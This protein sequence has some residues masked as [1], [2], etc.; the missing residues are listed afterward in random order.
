MD[1]NL[2]N[3][4]DIGVG[5][6]S[7]ADPIEYETSETQTGVATN[8]E[9]QTPQLGTSLKKSSSSGRRSSSSSSS[10][11]S[12]EAA[13]TKDGSD[14]AE[15]AD[16]A[17]VAMRGAPFA[18]FL[19]DASA[20]MQQQLELNA[21]S[22]AF[23]GVE[24]SSGSGS[25]GGAAPAAAVCLHELCVPPSEPSVAAAASGSSRSRSRAAPRCIPCTSVDWNSTG[26]VL[27]A[28]LGRNDHVGWCCANEE[29]HGAPVGLALWNVFGH[30]SSANANASAAG[31]SGASSER[32]Q[33]SWGGDAGADVA[34]LDAAE[35]P[36]AAAPGHDEALRAPDTFIPTS[37][38]LMCVAC[39][40]TSPGMVAGGTYTGEVILWD[41]GKAGDEVCVGTSPVGDYY[42]RDPVV[43]VC[44]C[45]CARARGGGSVA[46]VLTTNHAIHS[47]S[48]LPLFLLIAFSSHLSSPASPF[49]SSPLQLEWVYDVRERGHVLLSVSGCGRVLI[50]SVR[51]KLA[52]PIGGY[53]LHP[54]RNA[55]SGARRGAASGQLR[56]SAA[57]TLLGG[58]SIAAVA[59]HSNTRSASFVVGT[60]GGVLY[61]NE[62]EKPSR[63]PKSKSGG[64]SLSKGAEVFLSRTSKLQRAALCAHVERWSADSGA[65]S[66]R[67]SAIFDSEPKIEQV[68]PRLFLLFHS[69]V[70]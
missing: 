21:R 7:Q 38:C 35:R 13:S 41:T 68:G 49:L 51:N 39:H 24:L 55:R 47:P 25:L 65:R 11:S 46:C 31:G 64:P 32:D 57:S 5:C 27:A 45:V 33:W 37:S 10:S 70:D 48:P 4:H 28:S 16:D 36:P 2:Y 42:H 6:G 18:V 43:K 61:Q 3:S 69:I 20:L 29:Q 30:R 8:V 15:E 17:E 26:S 40:P 67:S 60:E 62:L 19:R 58:T 22:R 34:A 59:D 23:D 54:P 52:N 14:A 50:W 1:L 66:V 63:V 44:V 56:A 9:T 53:L 12:K